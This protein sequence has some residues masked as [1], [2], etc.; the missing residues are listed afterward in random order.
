[1]LC[2]CFFLLLLLSHVKC[3]SSKKEIEK[4][5]HSCFALNPTFL[6]H[7]NAAVKQM[8]YRLSSCFSIPVSGAGFSEAAY[9]SRNKQLSMKYN[10]TGRYSW[11][12]RVLR[13]LQEYTV[14]LILFV[15][16]WC[17]VLRS[18]SLCLRQS[19]RIWPWTLK[20]FC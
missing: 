16:L 20:D 14:I 12:V 8:Y 18:N 1:M 3:I 13:Y 4:I 9:Y 2:K 11:S 15:L 6:P 19:D 10:T 5:K 7:T 17:L